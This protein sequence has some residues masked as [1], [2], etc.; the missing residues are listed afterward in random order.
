MKKTL[1]TVVSLVLCLALLA[2]AVFAFSD[3]KPNYLVLGDS[4]AFGSGLTNPREAVYGKIVAD[5]NGYEYE[6]YAVPGH[7]TGNLMKRIEKE[8]ISASVAAADIIS[9]SIGGNNFLL[10]NVGAIL[11][12]GIVKNDFSRI[13]EIAT[14]FRTD[15]DEIVKMIRSFN[16]DAAILLQ[17]IYNPQTGAVGEVYAK[18]AELLNTVIKDYALANPDSLY[19]VDVAACLTDSERDFAEDGIH[20]SAEGNE[21][22]AAA[23]LETL[24]ENGLGSGTQPVINTKGRDLKGTGMMSFSLKAYTFFLRVIA[25]VRGFFLQAFS[26]VRI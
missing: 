19:V 21:K 22:I 6:N 7:T 11:Y 12:D 26:F 18:G 15:L 14:G 17:T 20:P 4:I 2:P 8:E 9:I 25:S 1:L 5:T 24:Y 16:P 10:G 23:V 3:E 13:E